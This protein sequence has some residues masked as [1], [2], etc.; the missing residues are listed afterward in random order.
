MTR[1]EARAVTEGAPGEA[2]EG[3]EQDRLRV[4]LYQLLHERAER[5]RRWQFLRLGAGH[6]VVG[7]ILAYAFLFD[8]GRFIALT[9]ILYGIVV[10]DGLKSSVRILYLQQQLTEVE[11]KLSRSEPLYNWVSQYGLFGRGRQ[12]EF[13][14]V[15]LNSLP[16]TFQY[17]LI[18]GIYVGLMIGALVAWTPLDGDAVPVTRELL[19]LG[20]ASFTLLFGLVVAIGYLHYQR[21]RRQI[22]AT[23]APPTGT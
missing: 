2:G 11:S 17:V 7:T 8:A 21:V 22:A 18:L 13:W 20:Y 10:M 5:E 14:D 3:D 23:A 19:I 1:D 16:E 6:L 15:D 12:I 4:D 9:P